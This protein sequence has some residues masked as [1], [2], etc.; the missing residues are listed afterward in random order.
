MMG[1]NL[2]GRFSPIMSAEIP[3]NL[4]GVIQNRAT[5]RFAY[6]GAV[7]LTSGDMVGNASQTTMFDVIG[8]LDP[9]NGQT[10]QVER[11]ALVA[12]VQ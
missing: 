2:T 5:M 1:L 10:G 6:V 11:Y 12:Q 9:P 4:L 3:N 7:S 8:L